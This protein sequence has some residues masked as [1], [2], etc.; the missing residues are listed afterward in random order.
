[1]RLGMRIIGN[2]QGG[3]LV[4]I[5]FKEEEYEYLIYARNKVGRG[6]AK[7]ISEGYENVYSVKTSTQEMV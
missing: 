6:E 1:M 7:E 2:W 4:S 5:C 3:T